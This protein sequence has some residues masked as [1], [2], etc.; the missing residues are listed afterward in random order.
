MNS[1]FHH[2]IA[3]CTAAGPGKQDGV[4]SLDELCKLL[5]SVDLDSY[6]PTGLTALHV[7]VA[8]NHLHLVKLLLTAGASPHLLSHKAVGGL[9]A[10]HIAAR[11]EFTSIA[12]L[13]LEA[14]VSP[15]ICS[16]SQSTPLHEAAQH[17]REEIVN[18]LLIKGACLQLPRS[19]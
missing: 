9:S 3:A 19:F 4:G 14:K 8:A 7:C 10:L 1:L 11:F 12:K 16:L 17:G 18:L 2:H 13:L 6:N 15:D 5:P